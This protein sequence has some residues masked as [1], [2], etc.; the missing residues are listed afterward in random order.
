MASVEGVSKEYLA[1]F[2]QQFMNA[3]QRMYAVDPKLLRRIDNAIE[4]EMK[5]EAQEYEAG[6]HF[7]S[8]D[9]K[10]AAAT[11]G[12][13]YVSKTQDYDCWYTIANSTTVGPSYM[14][15]NRKQSDLFHSSSWNELVLLETGAERNSGTT[16]EPAANTQGQAP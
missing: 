7:N 5:R 4:N 9:G 15:H 13:R 2:F 14:V 6:I 16:G 1:K 3:V 11:F 12:F 8:N 10:V